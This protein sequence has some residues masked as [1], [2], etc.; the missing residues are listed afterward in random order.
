MW[1]ISSI[2]S[3]STLDVEIVL[4]AEENLKFFVPV[5]EEVCNSEDV[6][7]WELP[8]VTLW[9]GDNQTIQAGEARGMY[10]VKISTYTWS[11]D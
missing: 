10:H 2:V 8:K 1:K 5:K 11:T 3:A 7:L 4:R 9:S 6:Q